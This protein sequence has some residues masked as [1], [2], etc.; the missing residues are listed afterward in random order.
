M[1]A[2]IIG[3]VKG[4]MEH[5]LEVKWDEYNQEVFVKSEIWTYVCK[6]PS[7]GEALKKAGEWVKEKGL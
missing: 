1:A 3:K 2:A 4:R 6:A 5:N 7:P